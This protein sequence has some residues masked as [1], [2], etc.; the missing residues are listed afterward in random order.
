M[1]LVG[2]VEAEGASREG[3][4]ASGGD[5]EDEAVAR[6]YHDT[7]LSGK[8]WQSECWAT[9]RESASSRMINAQRPGDRL[10]RSSGR[11]NQTCSSPP[12]ENP[13]CAAFEEY[14]KVL[15][16]VP[17]DFTEDGVTWVA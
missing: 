3:R 5:E 11:I 9:E 15:E 4:A 6:S 8:L 12:V 10:Q 7:V 1:G 17:L 16:T 13:A 2:D 14:G